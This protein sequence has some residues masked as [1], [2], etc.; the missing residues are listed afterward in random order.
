MDSAPGTA[1]RQQDGA[2]QQDVEY[3]P[4]V[5]TDPD[6]LSEQALQ[7]VSGSAF[8]LHRVHQRP[9]YSFA[10]DIQILSSKSHTLSDKTPV[11]KSSLRSLKT[12]KTSCLQASEPCSG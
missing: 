8:S 1:R 4:V 9:A 5:V 6:H 12:E 7:G 11:F 10:L 3:H 2:I